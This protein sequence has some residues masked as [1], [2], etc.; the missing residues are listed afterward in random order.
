MSKYTEADFTNANFAE[1]P[2]GRV[3]RFDTRAEGE[4]W[5]WVGTKFLLPEPEMV[6]NGWKPLQLTPTMTSKEF[7]DMLDVYDRGGA[8]RSRLAQRLGVSITP[9]PKQSNTDRIYQKLKDATADFDPKPLTWLNMADL[10]EALDRQGVEVP[11]ES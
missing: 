5:W 6:K 10:A 9:D 4:R 8:T 2:D 7:N 1:H 3:A 11:E